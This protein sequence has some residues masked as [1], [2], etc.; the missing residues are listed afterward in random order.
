MG[1]S[2]NCARKSNYSDFAGNFLDM[3]SKEGAFMG[4]S[5][6]GKGCQ[7]D[8]KVTISIKECPMPQ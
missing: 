7:D 4:I 2:V 3:V 1:L 6:I 8:C 5:K